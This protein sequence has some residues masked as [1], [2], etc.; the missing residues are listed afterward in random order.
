MC[1]APIRD[2]SRRAV[3][4]GKITPSLRRRL[5]PMA[6]DFRSVTPQ[7]MRARPLTW[8]RAARGGH[9]L[10]GCH[11]FIGSTPFQNLDPAVSR[12]L[13]ECAGNLQIS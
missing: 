12:A 6:R 11:S 8:A 1:L 3:A 5:I 13:S 10:P 2:S 4:P 9:A 7:A